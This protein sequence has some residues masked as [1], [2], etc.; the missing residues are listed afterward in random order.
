MKQ[1]KHKTQSPI[2]FCISY[3]IMGIAMI[4]LNRVDDTTLFYIVGGM[5]IGY[6][7]RGI[8]FG[9]WLRR[10]TNE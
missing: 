10:F 3:L 7:M 2:Y 6:G 5:F 1:N 8:I 9:V 4:L